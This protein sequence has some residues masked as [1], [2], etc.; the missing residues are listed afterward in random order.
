MK[1]INIPD[2]EAHGRRV[3]VYSGVG[4]CNYCNTE[5]E[6]LSVDTSDQEYCSFDCCLDC[7]TDLIKFA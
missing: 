2:I 7:F 4:K 3:L 5:K 1:L 6:I